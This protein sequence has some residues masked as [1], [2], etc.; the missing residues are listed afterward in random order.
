[1]ANPAQ[2]ADPTSD[3]DAKSATRPA[4]SRTFRRSTASTFPS[5]LLWLAISFGALYYFMA[6]MALPQSRGGD[7]AAQGA[8]RQ[9]SRRRH[10][11]AAEGGRR[12]RRAPEGARRGARQGAES[13]PGGARPAR[14]PKRKPSARR[15]TRSS[16]PSSPPPSAR[17]P[18]RAPR[19][20]PTSTRSPRDAA[21]AIV[22]RLIGRSGQAGGDRRRRRI[23]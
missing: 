15:S 11:D 7:P 4:A 20:W 2:D 8:H 10:R 22:E 18:R 9:G 16:R 17:S 14:R 12:R 5:Q 19:R 1:M 23:P 13:R 3:P 6:K 21:G